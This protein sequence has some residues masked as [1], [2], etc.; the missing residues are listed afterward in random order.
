MKGIGKAFGVHYATVSPAVRHAEVLDCK[1]LTRISWFTS[2]RNASNLWYCSNEIG[3]WRCSPGERMH[4]RVINGIGIV[5]VSIS[6]YS[7]PARTEGAESET[8]RFCNEGDS[9]LEIAYITAD[10]QGE[11]WAGGRK[12]VKGTHMAL[13]GWH[14]VAPHSCNELGTVFY[15]DLHV[16]IIRTDEKGKRKL[17]PYVGVSRTRG[18]GF[19]VLRTTLTDD[20]PPKYCIPAKGD[21]FRKASSTVDPQA[22]GG[23]P[24]KFIQEANL[25]QDKLKECRSGEDVE[26][27]F[28]I[29]MDFRDAIPYPCRMS[30]YTVRATSSGL[31]SVHAW[32]KHLDAC[33]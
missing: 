18:G 24:P 11:P 17:A 3:T 28:A 16:A 30:G 6:L 1:T 4:P 22:V 33:R 31:T 8:V 25:A 15:G 21:F 14:T 9:E 7:F 27:P 29:E 19:G 26:V 2:H 12:L 10:H 5:I 32:G 20:Q 23:L 13:T